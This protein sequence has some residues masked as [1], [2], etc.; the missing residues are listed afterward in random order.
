MISVENYHL[1]S[2]S[3]YE[4]LSS[5]EKN[6][7]R[8]HEQRQEY[9]KGQLLFKES[10]F[11]KGLYIIRK[12]KVKIFKSTVNGGQSIVYIYRKGDY[13]GYRPMLAEDPQ[14]TSAAAM[15]STVISFIPK[16]IFMNLVNTSESLAKNMLHTLAK[17]FS[18]WINKMTIF[19]EYSVKERVALSLLILDKIYQREGYSKTIISIG[20][21][22]L[23]G[24]AGTT[25]ETAVRNLR[26]FKDEGIIKTQGSKILLLKPDLLQNYF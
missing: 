1:K 21:D 14:P 15:D 8:K 6:L 17:E 19:T 25:K 23:A 16:D 22:D 4:S 18:V 24:F 20:R 26:L 10:S 11:A 5:K 12:G 9:K 13:F 7:I 3:F 2:T